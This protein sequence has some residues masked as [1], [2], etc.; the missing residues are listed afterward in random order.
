MKTR[1]GIAGGL[2]LLAVVGEASARAGGRASGS[3]GGILH[4][5]GKHHD[6]HVHAPLSDAVLEKLAPATLQSDASKVA[7]E[8]NG[9]QEVQEVRCRGLCMHVRLLQPRRP[10]YDTYKAVPREQYAAAASIGDF[11][12]HIYYSNRYCSCF[13]TSSRHVCDSI[14]V[15]YILVVQLSMCSYEFR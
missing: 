13:Y 4:S 6:E 1:A 15:S 12:R 11:V 14:A 5:A 10:L 3:T 9:G 7:L 8:V 2:V